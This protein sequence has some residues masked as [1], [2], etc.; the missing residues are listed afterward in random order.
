MKIQV[1]LEQ[2]WDF[3]RILRLIMG[4]YITVVSLI[5]GQYFLILPGVFFVYQAITNTGCA[6]CISPVDN[7]QDNQQKK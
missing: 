3:G 2:P 7:N 6:A 4:T 5:D 1:L